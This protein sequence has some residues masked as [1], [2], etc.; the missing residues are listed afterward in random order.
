MK[1]ETLQ[2]VVTCT[3]TSCGA[4]AHAKEPAKKNLPLVAGCPEGYPT[5]QSLRSSLVRLVFALHYR[6][7]AFGAQLCGHKLCGSGPVF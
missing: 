7:A 1:G 3:Q 2:R 4:A 5:A 6:Q